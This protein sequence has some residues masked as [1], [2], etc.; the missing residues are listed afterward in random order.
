MSN[1]ISNKLTRE[2][3]KLKFFLIGILRKQYPKID[4]RPKVKEFTNAD[5]YKSESELNCFISWKSTKLTKSHAKNYLEFIEMNRDVQF[6]L[7]DDNSQDDWMEE[8]FSNAEILSIYRGIKFAAS[9]SDIFR[10]CI[11]YKYGGFYTGINRTFNVKLSELFSDKDK[12]LISFEQNSYSRASKQLQIPG[13][14]RNLNMVQHS[15]FSPPRHKI[16][17]MAIE[18]IVQNA[19]LYDRV[20]FDSVK[21]A[22]WKFSAPYLLTDV[23]DE[24]LENYGTKDIEFCGIQF[25]NSCSIPV[26]SEFRYANS[27][28]YLGSRNRIIL[29]LSEV[30]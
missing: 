2:M 24:Y 14:Y 23:I 25:N 1:R 26:G 10:L 11:L 16:L 29:D 9:K 7:F 6:W 5:F 30:K 22:I 27:P 13:P 28:S 12:F 21:E 3:K 20:K 17:K 8:N 18:R 4:L 15:I 19:P